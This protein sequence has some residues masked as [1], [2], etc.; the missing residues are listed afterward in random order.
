V[1]YRLILIIN[2]KLL[3][4]VESYSIVEIYSI[5]SVLIGQVTVKGSFEKV[6]EHGVYVFHVNGKVH[7]I[8]I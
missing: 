2:N 7:K 5:S 3:I 8:I 4:R 6:V 1:F